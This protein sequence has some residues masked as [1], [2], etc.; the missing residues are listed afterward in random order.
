MVVAVHC[1]HAPEVHVADLEGLGPGHRKGAVGG[2]EI[3]VNTGVNAQ[4]TQTEV[5]VGGQFKQDVIAGGRARPIQRWLRVAGE[6][7]AGLIPN[8]QALGRCG[9]VD[10]SGRRAAAPLV[11]ERERRG[12]AGVRGFS[13]MELNPFTVGVGFILTT[14][15]N[16][17]VQRC[18]VAPIKVVL[19]RVVE[20][21]G[22][23]GTGLIA[24]SESEGRRT[25]GP[26]TIV[27]REAVG[28]HPI[29]GDAVLGPKARFFHAVNRDHRVA[30]VGGARQL[31][32]SV[33]DGQVVVQS[34]LIQRGPEVNQAFLA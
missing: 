3:A 5:F 10:R 30:G 18:I 1:G 12:I 21:E 25:V 24:V 13:R 17:H 28:G 34:E 26:T 8:G 15:R 33:H 16:Q 20:V 11:G 27:P 31:H 19:D 6:V 2:T 23:A 4:F 22:K 9:Q 14:D 29:P 32:L 7:V